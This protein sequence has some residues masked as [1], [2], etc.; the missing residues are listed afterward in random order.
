MAVLWICFDNHAAD[1]RVW[2]IREGRKWH[3]AAYVE[4]QIPVQ[5]VYR[6]A[7]ARQPRAYFRAEGVVVRRG[8]TLIIRDA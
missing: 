6:G 1:G 2:A 4:I 5:S 7:H 3:R 8:T